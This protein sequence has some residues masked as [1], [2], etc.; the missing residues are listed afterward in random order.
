M[1]HSPPSL[2]EHAAI[3]PGPCMNAHGISPCVRQGSDAPAASMLQC[4]F[5]LLFVLML[6]SSQQYVFLYR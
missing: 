5:L 2:L 3:I 6:N 4:I 1:H